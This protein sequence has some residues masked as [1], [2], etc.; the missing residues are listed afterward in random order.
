MTVKPSR[1]SRLSL[2]DPSSERR[3]H[4]CLSVGLSVC[5]SVCMSVCLSVFHH[6]PYYILLLYPPAV[7]RVVVPCALLF[8]L[9]ALVPWP[10]GWNSTT[11]IAKA[12][13]PL[14]FPMVRS[15]SGAPCT[16]TSWCT[17]NEC[18]MHRSAPCT[19]V[20]RAPRHQCNQ[21]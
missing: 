12:V 3:V 15:S 1:L 5:L 2:C 14:P 8:W 6:I 7:T 4:V 13:N 18:T 10:Y 17:K 19:K 16:K 20:H 9:R 21:G 11:V